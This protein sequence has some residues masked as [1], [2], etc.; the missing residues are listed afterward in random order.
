MDDPVAGQPAPEASASAPA[1]AAID[2]D[3][4]KAEILEAARK[5][6]DSRVGGFQ[7]VINRLQQENEQL[8][9]AQLPEEERMELDSQDNDD[10]VAELE[11]QL[12]LMKLAQEFPDV[13]PVY[14]SLLDAETPEEQVAILVA[15][16][17]SSTAQATPEAETQ[18]AEIDKN[19][20]AQTVGQI[21]G[22]M[23]DG[24]PLTGDAAW[25]WLRQQGSTPVAERR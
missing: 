21:V 13:A 5:E 24:T 8:R 10:R 17:R 12:A 4:I 18:V 6:T 14:Q 1:P 11:R 9:R 20:P 22:R 16:L 7:T 25:D 2:I 19:N 23:P 3:K 15:G